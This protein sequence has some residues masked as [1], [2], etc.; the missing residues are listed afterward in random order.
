MLISNPVVRELFASVVQKINAEHNKK[1]N[2]YKISNLCSEFINNNL[3]T[4][5]YDRH[6]KILYHKNFNKTYFYS[7]I[8]MNLYVL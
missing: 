3:T 4:E 1:F 2:P 8:Y 6:N 5:V 7:L